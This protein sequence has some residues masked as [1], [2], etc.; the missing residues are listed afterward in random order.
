MI[1]ITTDIFT[2][3]NS[4]FSF[5]LIIFAISLFILVLI[6]KFKNYRRKKNKSCPSEEFPTI[7]ADVQHTTEEHEERNHLKSGLPQK[8]LVSANDSSSSSSE[9]ESDTSNSIEIDGRSNNIIKTTASA[10]RWFLQL[11]YNNGNELLS[12]MKFVYLIYWV[13]NLQN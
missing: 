9:C 7:I 8:V 6:S 5:M 2:L 3:V 11:Y 12:F 13:V 1:I 10:E 4:N